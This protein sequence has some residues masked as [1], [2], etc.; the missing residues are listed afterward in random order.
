MAFQEITAADLAN[1][2]EQKQLAGFEEIDASQLQVANPVLDPNFGG[3]PLNQPTGAQQVTGIASP[4]DT[5]YRESITPKGETFA[6][7]AGHVLGGFLDRDYVAQQEKSA[8]RTKGAADMARSLGL[9]YVADKL[10]ESAA[11]ANA[12]AV[13]VSTYTQERNPIQE[14]TWESG[15]SSA[16]QSMTDQAPALLSLGPI[17]AGVKVTGAGI[18][19]RAAA[20]LTKMA[21]LL[22]MGEATAAEAY[23]RYRGRGIDPLTAMVG[24]GTE[25]AIEMGTEMLSLSPILKLMKPEAQVGIEA[26]AAQIGKSGLYEYPGEAIATFTQSL[27][28]KVLAKPG[29]TAKEQAKAIEDYVSEINPKTGNPQAL[30]DFY[31]TMRATTVQNVMMG[32]LGAGV[33]RFQQKRQEKEANNL[34]GEIDPAA[35]EQTALLNS[36]NPARAGIYPKAPISQEATSAIPQETTQDNNVQEGGATLSESGDI[37]GATVEQPGGTGANGEGEPLASSRGTGLDG[38]IQE[39]APMQRLV[40]RQQKLKA[41]IFNPDGSEKPSATQ[42]MKDNYAAVTAEIQRQEA[43][44]ATEQTMAEPAQGEEPSASPAGVIEPLAA[45]GGSTV[46]GTV[47]G[48]PNDTLTAEVTDATKDSEATQVQPGATAETGTEAVQPAEVQSVDGRSSEELPVVQ[49]PDGIETTLN[50]K[51]QT[52][53]RGKVEALGSVD[54]VKAAYQDPKS[55]VHKYANDLAIKLFKENDNGQVQG[56]QAEEIKTDAPGAQAV[57]D[58]DTPPTPLNQQEKLESS[59]ATTGAALILP[60]SGNPY[61]SQQSAKM[62]LGKK[63]LG[64]THEVV[65]HEGGFAIAPKQAQGASLAPVEKTDQTAADE[66]EKVVLP[67]HK[68][69]AATVNRIKKLKEKSVL[70]SDEAKE[71]ARL[72]RK[73]GLKVLTEPAPTE[74]KPSPLKMTDEQR[75]VE[76]ESIKQT[77]SDFGGSLQTY[78]DL[79]HAKLKDNS[80]APTGRSMKEIMAVQPFVINTDEARPLYEAYRK[81]GITHAMSVHEASKTVAGYAW[82]EALK[83]KDPRGNN[84]VL[85][86]GGGGGSG[87]GSAMKNEKQPGLADAYWNSQIIYDTT[88]SNYSKAKTLILDALEAGKQVRIAHIFRNLDQAVDGVVGRKYLEN[89]DVPTDILAEDHFLAGQVFLDLFQLFKDNKDVQFI[90]VDNTGD[91]DSKP[92]SID[93]L[94]ALV[95]SKV[96]GHL[97]TAKHSIPPSFK[98]LV[99][100]LYQDAEKRHQSLQE[101]GED[102][103]IHATGAGAVQQDPGQSTEADAGRSSEVRSGDEAAGSGV[104]QQ[105]QQP[106]AGEVSNTIF[107]EAAAE[108][109]RALLRAKLSQ[110]NTGIDPEIMQAGITLAGYHIEKGARTFAAYSKAML[111]DLG[112]MVK[113]YLKSWYLGVKFDPRAAGFEGMD[114]AGT[115]ESADMEAQDVNEPSDQ[116]NGIGNNAGVSESAGATAATDGNGT[117]GNVA[118]KQPGAIQ[119]I[120]SGGSDTAVV[121]SADRADDTGDGPGSGP[122]VSAPRPTRDIADVSS[123]THVV[124]SSRNFTIT[125]LDFSGKGDKTKYRDNVAAIRIVKQL[126]AE[127]RPATPEEQEALSRYVGWGGLANVF[128]DKK[129]DWQKEYSEL[130]DL[131]TTD[132]YEA[133]R[134]STRNAHYTAENIVRA[135]WQAIQRLGFDRGTVLEPSVGT[136]NFFGMM[137]REIRGMSNLTGIELDPITAKIA[138]YLYP[139]AKV[140]NSGFQDIQITPGSYDL[141]IG[142]PPFAKDGVFDPASKLLSSFNLHGYFFA[143]SIESLRPGGVLA[144]VVSDSLLDNK[145]I[146]TGIKQ[147]QWM[148]DRTRLLGAIRLPN[149]AFRKN[150]GTDV[151]TDI[152]LLQKL[153][154]GEAGN[155]AE[156]LNVGT[157]K[158]RETGADIT[159]NQYFI[160]HPEMML[161]EMALAGKH[162]RGGGQ[163]LV[164]RVGDDLSTLLQSAIESLPQGVMI[165]GKDTEQ[166]LTAARKGAPAN[167][168]AAR[169]YNHF[170]T[171]GKLYQRIPDINGEATAQELDLKGKPAER[172][173]GMIGIRELLRKQLQLESDPATEISAIDTNRVEL[174]RV[175]DE[176][177]KVHGY[178]SYDTNKRLFWDDADSPLIR[179]LEKNFDKGI[180]SDQAKKTNVPERKPS[181]DKADIFKKRVITPTA[182]VTKVGS[183]TD[184][185]AAS[186][187]E[188]GRVDFPFMEKI[189][190]KGQEAIVS[191]LGDTV[192]EDPSAGWQTATQ[193]LAGNVKAKLAEAIL[194]AKQDPRYE[195]N[196]SALAEVIPADVPA[197]D[198]FVAPHSFWIPVEV[199]HQFA[200]EIFKGKITGGYVKA[201]GT[202]QV[203]FESGDPIENSNKYGTQRMPGTKILSLLMAN[204]SVEVKDPNPDRDKAP[205]INKDETAAAQAKADE[206]VELFQDWIWKDQDRRTKVVRYYNDTMN[207]NIKTSYD[208]SHLTLPGKISTFHYRPH[209][210]NVIYRMLQN[211]VVLLDHV[212]GSGKTAIMTAAAMEMRRLGLAKKPMITVPNH[213]VEQWA[214]SFT[215]LYPNAKVLAATKKDLAKDKR[216]EMFAKIATGDWDVVIVAHSSFKF[217]PVPMETQK[218]ILNEQVAEYMGAIREAKEREGKSLTVKRLEEARDKIK[219]K[220][221]ELSDIVKDDLLDFKEMGVDALF[222]DE[223]HEF[224]NLYYT[225]T[226]QNVAGLGSPSG[227]G[228][229]FDMFVKTQYLARRNGGKGIHFATGTPVSNSLAEVYHMQRFLQYQ[230]LQARGLA[231]FDAWASA[232]GRA[233]TDWEQD[234]GGRFKQK[235]RF[236]S[237]VNLPE[238]KSVW[239]QVVDTVTNKQVMDDATAQGKPF[240]LPNMDGGKPKNIVVERSPQ[241][242]AFIGVPI[243]KKDDNGD[244]VYDTQTG[245]PIVEYNPGTIVYRMD[246]WQQAQKE[247]NTREMPLV[248]TGEARKAGLDYRLIDDTAPDWAGSK[249]NT[250]VSEILSIHQENNHRKGTQLVFC[251][252]STP[253]SQKGKTLDKLA[254]ISPVLFVKEKGTITHVAGKQVK[255]KVLPGEEFFY[256]DKKRKDGRSVIIYE[257]LTGLELGR[258]NDLNSAKEHA[259]ERIERTGVEELTNRLRGLIIPTEQIDEYVARWEEEQVKVEDTTDDEGPAEEV[260]FDDILADAGNSNFSVYDDMRDKLVAKGIPAEQI[261]FIHDYNTDAQK[262][263]L[264]DKVNKGIVRILFGSTQKMGAGTNVQK[265]LV[266]LHHMDAP[267]KPSDLAQREGRIVRQGNVFWNEASDEHDPNFVVKVRRYATKQTYDSRMWEI[268]EIKAKAIEDFRTGGSDVREV[269]DVSSESANAA[270][271]KASSAGNPLML[272]D[273]QLKKEVQRLTGIEKSWKR[274][275]FDLEDLVKQVETKTTWGHKQLAEYQAIAP[276]VQAKNYEAL[277]LKI[278]KLT[279]DTD[280]G[281]EKAEKDAI[282]QKFGM[283]IKDAYQDS[284]KKERVTDIGSYRGATVKMDGRYTNLLKILVYSETGSKI[285]ETDYKPEDGFTLHGFIRRL[286]NIIDSVPAQ[287][288][289]YTEMVAESERKAATAREELKQPFKYQEQLAKAKEQH[290]KVISAL[291]SGKKSIDETEQPSTDSQGNSIHATPG[292]ISSFWRWF[293]DSKAVDTQGRP[294]VYYHGTAGSFDQ[295]KDTG[296]GIFFTENPDDAHHFAKQKA[297]NN[298]NTMPVYLKV[299]KPFDF[300]N[301]T[302]LETVTDALA[303]KVYHIYDAYEDD[304]VSVTRDELVKKISMGDFGAI[305]N[306]R[307]KEIMKDNGYDGFYI[308]ESTHRTEE[309]PNLAVF[310]PEQIKSAIGNSGKF[311]KDTG[312]ILDTMGLQQI[313]EALANSK[314]AQNAKAHLQTMGQHFYAQG[315]TAWKEWFAA[316]KEQL[317]KLFAKYRPMLEGVFAKLKEE[318]GSFSTAPV[319][320]A[321]K[322]VLAKIGSPKKTMR[323]KWDKLMD[324]AGLKLEQGVFDQ[325]ASLKMVDNLA[326]VTEVDDSA[327]V[328]A[329]MSTSMSDVLLAM[330]KF[331]HPVWNGGGYDVAG[332]GLAEVFQPVAD[333][334]EQFLGWMVGE[335]A[336]K[337]M[338]EGRERYFSQ[339][340]INELKALKTPEN[341]KRWEDA[342][343][344]YVRYKTKVLDF[345][346]EAG[347]IN[348]GA[349]AIWDH[350][351]YVPFYRVQEDRVGGPMNKRG[352]AS[353]SSGIRTLKGG[354]SPLGDIFENILKNFTHLTDAAI[355]NHATEL[356]IRGAEQIGVA[357]KAPNKWKAVQIDAQQIM[358]N[359]HEIVGETE[360]EIELFFSEQDR[361]GFLTLFHPAR[362]EG[363]TIIHVLRDGKPEYYDIHD[364]LVLNSLTS[365]NIKNDSGLAMKGARFLKR[366]V[367]IGITAAP[368]F[369][370]R[371]FARDTLHTWTITRG[372]PFQFVPVISSLKGAVHAFRQDEDLQHLMAAGGAFYGGHVTGNDPAATKLALDR[373]LKKKGIDRNKIANTPKK[374]WELW[375]DLG[376]AAEN[377]ARVQTYREDRKAGK[378]HLESAFNAKDLMDFSMRGDFKTIRFL[379]EV[380]PFLGARIQGMQRL[381]KGAMENP[382]A[383]LLKGTAIAIAS[384]ML[385]MINADDDRY[386]EL[387]EWDKDTYYHIFIGDSHW[388]LP[389]PFEVGVL[390]G[391]VPERLIELGIQKEGKL[392]AKRMFAALTQTMSI[393]W[394]QFMSEPMQQYANKD[395]FTGRP[396]VGEAE[397]G[398]LPVDQHTYRTSPTAVKMGEMTGASPARIE[399]AVKG[400]LGTMGLYL[401]GAADM[402]TRKLTDSPALPASRPEDLHVIKAFYRGNGPAYNTKYTTEF[403]EL[404]QEVDETYKSIQSRRKTGEIDSAEKLIDTNANKLQARGMLEAGRKQLSGINKRIKIIHLDRNMTSAEKR[405]E[406]DTLQTRKNELTKNIMDRSREIGVR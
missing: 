363:Q 50:E 262:Q 221:S 315:K 136:G 293:G 43:T 225:T 86:L 324:R 170:E 338:N 79:A 276:T 341:A 336:Q 120:V 56:N 62:Q 286:D 175:Y 90:A 205:V 334:I 296:Y 8:G 216:K 84:T 269:E 380:V 49:Q 314:S 285:G 158:D 128:D 131:F 7:S 347:V 106:Q 246:N 30:D 404:L 229:A 137:P 82:R 378:S 202:W 256:L 135:M 304:H 280:E 201:T 249:V 186:M 248:I 254:A 67:A 115:V 113:P 85:F 196:V 213:L 34:F 117:V 127:L 395:S 112:E 396:I 289:K 200:K 284:G 270:E 13:K 302:D 40:A 134:A 185:L 253:K 25:G 20:G 349:R 133:A 132:E 400:Y 26:I 303:N 326:G 235:T 162:F 384:A 38:P 6:E 312:I 165:A 105:H 194:A 388:R 403:Y 27:T 371:N 219:N 394:P 339:E 241:Q 332:K 266:G 368:D 306:T 130:R 288:A 99:A 68:P 98:K 328:A 109:A 78:F 102:N 331:G 59:S 406:I 365:L 81:D 190:G 283:A 243:E 232:F 89:R 187:N 247:G 87:K 142:N 157:V 357:T 376:A 239:G 125:S 292:G 260:S 222:V 327:Y 178:V 22:P 207:T 195:R 301:D 45:D 364:E 322:A 126:E 366:L 268:N 373:L 169:I 44:S 236:R 183:A 110:L 55:A 359:I 143:K 272:E 21:P 121:E 140:H 48:Q 267:W 281:L 14:G 277:G 24:A 28:D 226:M 333:D 171:D 351:E 17:S 57:M 189:Y 1:P 245:M 18:L 255:L 5:A 320:D 176:F 139:Q 381:G 344:E 345:A 156:W 193:Y 383:F 100:D 33:G 167:T 103:V 228:R 155:T 356:A 261:A 382:S 227:S 343:R 177:V 210:L 369:M 323:Q 362:P 4:G 41:S 80:K 399:H 405:E 282:G 242:A 108:K 377:A 360:E 355:K 23:G 259:T 124:G 54:A 358:K 53:V 230:E 118:G 129:K 278:G 258:G 37:Q 233:T 116:N 70:T 192:Y 32:G 397:Q 214:A 329:R 74:I 307:V 184:A 172:M 107:T 91:F 69:D 318:R 220:L 166:L 354:E 387:E 237:L 95:D 402:V 206:L 257:R 319:T 47:S 299:A 244:V 73:A 141:A 264:F 231:N 386:K 149:N 31:D 325:F 152:V 291:R 392:F 401:L 77:V 212:V 168:A 309:E 160:D 46:E 35:A 11:E 19:T 218:E 224:K 174:N 391:T 313:Y 10:D 9:T 209:Q 161:G 163:A 101:G 353:Q 385:Y 234:A 290:A 180:S 390:F 147:R 72:Q 154:P 342:R 42:K 61:P 36:M 310:A 97:P 340:E 330:M 240:W 294:K 211:G 348:A 238:L 199:Y 29:M 350:E 297:D 215:K 179:S 188:K 114:S 146:G 298:L 164:A 252:L 111:A 145:Q 250:A 148:G 367:T 93:N 346:Q 64:E 12:R 182:V 151:T 379:T 208:G 265:R 203:T 16:L 274:G 251:D 311:G 308:Y 94:R 398:L 104:V 191:E 71:L 198:I 138:K 372:G 2:K 271:I 15:F 393:G 374:L 316:M 92:I 96:E 58:E 217:I 279:Y 60:A 275:R 173:R 88:L 66:A 375:Q 144:M 63:K 181:A 317:G 159:I 153:A 39:V 119:E 321:Q 65:P 287:I 273:L 223:A 389:K 204:K 83:V 305:E 123:P 335:R 52:F 76:T 3:V 370:I 300:R 295:F 197:A 361:E 122:E 51:Q 150:A 337:L 75:A 263:A 352:L